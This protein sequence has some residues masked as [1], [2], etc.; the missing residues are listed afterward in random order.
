MVGWGE[1]EE[2]EDDRA[3][4]SSEAGMAGKMESRKG[5]AKTKGAQSS[6]SG[7]SRRECLKPSRQ[8]TG[9]LWR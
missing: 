1:D 2:D 5:R 8:R 3:E 9:L 4:G 6:R 7:T